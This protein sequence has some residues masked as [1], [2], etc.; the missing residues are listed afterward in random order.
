MGEMG[1]GLFVGVSASTG[2]PHA[3]QSFAPSGISLSQKVQVFAADTDS[4][5]G[6]GFSDWQCQ[7][8][9]SS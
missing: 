6:V 4:D 8:S 9:I 7:A 3:G 5:M 1:A 2:A